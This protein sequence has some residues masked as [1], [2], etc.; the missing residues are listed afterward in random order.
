MFFEVT[1]GSLG[2][3][4]RA[5]RGSRGNSWALQATFPLVAGLYTPL[6]WMKR[7]QTRHHEDGVSVRK[8]QAWLGHESLEGTLDYLGVEDAAYEI[9]QE[10]VNRNLLS[11]AICFIY[12]RFPMA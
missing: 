1:G 7:D 4:W 8:I 5:S 12:L 2:R 9:S 6:A 11:I 3:I 10:Q